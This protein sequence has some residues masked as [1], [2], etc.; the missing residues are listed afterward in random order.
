MRKD[1][2]IILTMAAIIIA[3]GLVMLSQR[4]QLIDLENKYSLLETQHDSLMLEQMKAQQ[5]LESEMVYETLKTALIED[6]I[7]NFPALMHNTSTV[8]LSTELIGDVDVPRQVGGYT[9]LILDPDEIEARAATEGAF[10][11]LRF[12]RFEPNP[13]ILLVSIQTSGVFDSVG[14]MSIQFKLTGKTYGA[15]IS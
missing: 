11:Y 14:G 13:D 10:L 3:S 8:V 1:Q 6:R 2:A 5:R 9:V 7:P 15:W 12:T 4:N